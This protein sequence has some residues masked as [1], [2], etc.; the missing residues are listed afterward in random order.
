MPKENKIQLLWDIFWTFFKIGPSTF[1]GGYAMIPV[2]EREMV[3]RKG[4]VSEHEMADALS[5]AGSAPGGIGVNAS[6]FIGF[7]LAGIPGAIAA[8]FGITMPT[9][10][11]IFALSMTISY[12]HDNP[13]VEAALQGI[14]GA[15]VALI[16]VAA[17]KMG[18]SAIFDK[19]TFF[20]AAATLILL[21]AT[22]I[23]PQL[24]V[25]LGLAVGIPVIRAKMKLGLPANTEKNSAESEPIHYKYADYFIA[26]GI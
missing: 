23:Q 1:G 11:I 2:I 16:I 5:I 15:I 8:V 24:I 26:E 7:R 12:F 18:K 20:T 10:L 19:T 21:L 17:Y 3:G 4:W 13:K 9:F 22:S 6:A 14:H 25:L